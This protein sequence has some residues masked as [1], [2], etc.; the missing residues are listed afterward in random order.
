MA[1]DVN[2]FGKNDYLTGKACI[3]HADVRQGKFSGFRNTNIG[4]VPA[5]VADEGHTKH[6]GLT[7]YF[8][9]GRP[10]RRHSLNFFPKNTEIW[11]PL[12]GRNIAGI[13]SVV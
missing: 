2:F 4:P 1:G 8:K 9:L 3:A 7:S 12:P 10:V 5:I 13:V 11:R 6:G